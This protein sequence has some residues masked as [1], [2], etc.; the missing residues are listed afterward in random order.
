MI[1]DFGFGVDPTVSVATIGFVGWSV[2][3]AV[4]LLKIGGQ[5]TGFTSARPIVAEALVITS[6]VGFLI[7]ELAL[8]SETAGQSDFEMAMLAIVPISTA[9]VGS[10]ALLLLLHGRSPAIGMFGVASVVLIIADSLL[11][12][13]FSDNAPLYATAHVLYLLTFTLIVIACFLPHHRGRPRGARSTLT[14]AGDRVHADGRR[15]LG[16]HLALLH[17]AS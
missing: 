7:W 16:G 13:W 11:T 14:P 6:C 10:I 17:P 9:L 4:G 8:A 12:V 2:L 1:L 5:N 15:D 3:T